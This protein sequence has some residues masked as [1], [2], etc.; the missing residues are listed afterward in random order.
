MIRV[1]GRMIRRPVVNVTETEAGPVIRVDDLENPETWVVLE[2]PT[3]Q[4]LL[5]A[6][7]INRRLPRDRGTT[8]QPPPETPLT[9]IG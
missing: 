3:V 6:A 4:V 5:W 8:D 1:S 9:E 7:A 2:V